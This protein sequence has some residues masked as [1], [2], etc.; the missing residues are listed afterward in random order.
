MRLVQ[1]TPLPSVKGRLDHMGI[2]LQGNRLFKATVT[3]SSMKVLNLA[4]ARV[5]KCLLD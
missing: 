1:T 3:N 5:I 4:D 2:D